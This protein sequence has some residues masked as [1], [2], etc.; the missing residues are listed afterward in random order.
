ML[1]EENADLMAWADSVAKR[2]SPS[3]E[4]FVAR[5]MCARACSTAG[6]ERDVGDLTSYVGQKRAA[7]SLDLKERERRLRMA[8]SMAEAQRQTL[9]E[10]ARKVWAEGFNPGMQEKKEASTGRQGRSAKCHCSNSL[11][12]C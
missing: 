11:T 4:S 7:A 10:D 6:N 12:F 5:A 3:L 1:N 8:R 9:C 2:K